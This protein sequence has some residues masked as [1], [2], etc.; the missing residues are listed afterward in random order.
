MYLL[1]TRK[2][3]NPYSLLFCLINICSSSL[4]IIYGYIVLDTSILVISFSYIEYNRIQKSNRRNKLIVF[5]LAFVYL[6]F[7][8]LAFIK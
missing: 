5:Y 6:A 8:Y 4:W 1:Y 7:V 2:S 3:T